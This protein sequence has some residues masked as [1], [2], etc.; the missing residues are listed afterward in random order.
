[1]PM[2]TIKQHLKAVIRHF[3]IDIRNS[4]KRLL[5]AAVLLFCLSWSLINPVKGFE[6]II[7]SQLIKKSRAMAL[8]QDQNQ[9]NQSSENFSAGRSYLSANVLANLTSQSDSLENLD[10]NLSQDDLNL[11]SLQIGALLSQNNPI[12]FISQ[13]PRTGIIAYTV[14]ENDNISSIAASFGVTVNTVLWANNLRETSI[15][16]PGD[17]LTILPVTGLI[18]RVRS[19]QTIDWIANYYK[20]N[21]QEIIAFN[22]LPADGSIQIGEKLVIPD[23]QMPV[24]VQSAPTRVASASYTGEGTGKSRNFPYGQCTW[25]VAQKRIVPWS[26]HAK[27]WLANSRA[28]GYQTGSVP[29]I[30]AIIVTNESWYGHVGYVEAIEGNWITFSE[31]NHLGWGIKSVRTIHINSYRIKGYIY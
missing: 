25:Y 18:H 14:Q 12:T 30:G 8:K 26:G 29:R 15:I 16:R 21:S 9:M 3:K 20:I 28:Y 17:E 5:L 22:S 4:N 11:A 23:G 2:G 24:T 27:S 19:N 1:V 31:M 13:E 7:V 10:Q 6:Q